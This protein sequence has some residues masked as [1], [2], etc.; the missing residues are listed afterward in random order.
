MLV[1]YARAIR[2]VRAVS[3][4]DQATLASRVP[5]TGSYLSLLERG[6][7]SPSDATVAAI[8]QAA[9]C[10]REVFDLLA[11]RPFVEDAELL[12]FWR[13]MTRTAH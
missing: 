10:P 2:V 8:C 7:R 9:A 4:L 5:C 13:Y 3:G 1:N 12:A 6:K 11:G